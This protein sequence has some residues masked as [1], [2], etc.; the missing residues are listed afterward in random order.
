MESGTIELHGG[1]LV[2]NI[3]SQ[4][5]PH[6][7]PI[8]STE[9]IPGDMVSTS[10]PHT[11]IVRKPQAAI[12]FV[13]SITDNVAK[14]YIANLGPSCPY[15]PDFP[16]GDLP[17]KVGDRM[18]IW[19][20]AKGGIESR[21]LYSN[22]AIDDAPCL[23]KMY[24]LYK[25][26]DDFIYLLN[27]YQKPLYTLDGVVNHNTLNTFT[28]DPE[29]S[30][31]FDDA[32]SVDVSKNTVYVHIVDIASADCQSLISEQARRRLRERCLTLYLSN[33]HTEHLLDPE[34]ASDKLSLI[35]GQE[36]QV[37]TVKA[38]LNDNG[39]V[40][41]FDIYRSTIVVKNRYTYDEVSTLL[42][43]KGVTPELTYLVKLTDNRSSNVKYNI[44][45][46]SMR[47][48]IDKQ[49][50]HINNIHCESTND[51]SH[52]LVATAMILA[53]LIVSKHLHFCNVKLPNR[54]H[55]SLHGM[56]NPNFTSTNNEH[57]DSFILV[58]RYARACYSV[59]K[60]G[61]FGL[62]LTDY[63]HF[64]SP[65]RRYADVIVHWILSGAVLN[66]QSIEE[67]VEWMNF[68][69][70]VVRSIQDL[71]STWKIAR[72]IQY[73]VDAA[74]N[75]HSEVK[76]FDIWI[77]DVK[78]GGVLWFMPDMSLNGFAHVSTL[79][80]KQFWYFDYSKNTLEGQFNGVM[81]NVGKKFKASLDS[82][83][84]ITFIPNLIIYTS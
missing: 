83:D 39:I 71:Y 31:D 78:K 49:S 64:T 27:D 84:P 53:N 73:L 28:I 34:V 60:K 37:I 51:D 61:H 81:V 10:H 29:S 66:E 25:K 15:I 62:G 45:L 20:D 80:P 74:K 72:H 40:Q 4:D 36:R 23:L 76:N 2:I 57:V 42:K 33:E 44:N 5:G 24:S 82:I 70:H 16:V 47:F 59:D 1:K 9:F 41:E 35:K 43:G 69:S 30:E 11:L 3:P 63:V 75:S 65:M 7:V 14:L 6:I 48:K 67:E 38:V 79:S 50:G 21:G 8:I 46:P 26:R 55:E 77:T 19:L 22:D 68:R 12:A 56:N 58:K 13:K 52:K 32:I 54:F 17:L 18:V